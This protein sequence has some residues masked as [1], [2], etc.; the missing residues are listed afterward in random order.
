MIIFAPLIDKQ[1]VNIEFEYPGEEPPG[2]YIVV[3]PNVTE[4]EFLGFETKKTWV[5]PQ[6]FEKFT[7]DLTRVAKYKIKVPVGLKSIKRLENI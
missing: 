6:E 2:V 5:P 1:P 7:A 3:G 4:M